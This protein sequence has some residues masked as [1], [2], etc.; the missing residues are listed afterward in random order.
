MEV[1]NGRDEPQSYGMGG[2]P[3]RDRFVS[4][5]YR[6][7]RVERVHSQ[8][9]GLLKLAQ[10]SPPG[11]RAIRFSQPSPAKL[12]TQIRQ[13]RLGTGACSRTD[14]PF[15][16][17]AAG[18]QGPPLGALGT[19]VGCEIDVVKSPV[20][21]RLHRLA[22]WASMP[23]PAGMDISRLGTYVRVPAGWPLARQLHI[24]TA[25]AMLRRR[26]PR[27]AVSAGFPFGCRSLHCPRLTTLAAVGKATIG[28]VR[29]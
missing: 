14:F 28:N 21:P 25:L 27:V 8:S 6:R 29:T 20:H 17:R 12:H 10:L 23:N 19:C 3:G 4:S 18:A 1:S 16:V 13:P 24:C 22:S 2:Q 11:T 5:P 15:P 26:W 9:S 7:D